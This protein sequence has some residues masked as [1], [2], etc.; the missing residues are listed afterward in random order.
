VTGQVWLDSN[1]NGKRDGYEVGSGGWGV[2]LWQGATLLQTKITD[3]YGNYYFMDLVPGTYS[4]EL[5]PRFST[6]LTTA[7]TQTRLLTRAATA[8][9]VDFG[10]KKIAPVDYS[11]RFA[12][13][14]NPFNPETTMSFTVSQR[15]PVSLRIYNV[16]G[17]L[18]RTVIDGELMPGQ[19]HRVWDGRDDAGR[20]VASG[21][22]FGKLVT[23]AGSQTV[24]MV[25]LK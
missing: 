21:V 18:V 8:G 25:L 1:G 16:N 14:P 9:H 3:Y 6:A 10:F 12:I 17:A 7:D 20:A 24:K 19:H 13:V 4:V 22:Y 11:R 5:V 2:Q 23:S 15:T